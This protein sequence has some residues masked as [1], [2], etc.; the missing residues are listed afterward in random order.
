[1][2]WQTVRIKLNEYGKGSIWIDDKELTAT[3]G[4]MVETRSGLPPLITVRILANVEYEGA[5]VVQTEWGRWMKA[6]A[7]ERGEIKE[8]DDGDSY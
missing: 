8:T 2:T 4:V 7:I 1:M 5:A 3:C 6:E